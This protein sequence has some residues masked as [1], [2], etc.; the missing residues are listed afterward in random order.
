MYILNWDP[1]DTNTDTYGSQLSY[2]SDGSVRYRNELEPAGKKIHWWE[3]HYFGDPDPLKGMRYGSKRLPQLPR[4][5]VFSLHF[6]GSTVPKNSVGLTIMSFDRSGQMLDQKM[7]LESDL[8]FE[9]NDDEQEYEV[10]LVKFNNTELIF[11][12]LLMIP[13]TMEKQYQIQSHL[14]QGYIDFIPNKRVKNE[15]G[16]IMVRQAHRVVDSIM[17]PETELQV[18]IRVVLI[19]DSWNAKQLHQI[20]IDFK[21][22]FQLTHANWVASDLKS[23]ALLNQKAEKSNRK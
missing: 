5:Q 21:K 13:E 2:Q 1:D 4:N 11:Q 6:K 16:K 3:T 14:D 23:Q 19:N 8:T 9:L 18:P 20:E 17:L 12:S 22:H 15:P 10:D 7:T